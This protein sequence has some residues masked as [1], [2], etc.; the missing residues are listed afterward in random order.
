MPG[1][2]GFSGGQGAVEFNTFNYTSGQ[3]YDDL[4]L[5][6]GKHSLKFGFNAE[7]RGHNFNQTKTDRGYIY[8]PTATSGRINENF[9]VICAVQFNADSFYQ[10][11]QLA[12]RKM[13]SRGFQAQASYTW[14]KSIDTASVTF[15]SNEYTNTVNNPVPFDTRVSRG[16]SDFDVRHNFVLNFVWDIPSPGAWSSMARWLARGWQLG[17]ICQAST[18]TPFSVGISGDKE[19]QLDAGNEGAIRSYGADRGDA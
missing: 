1:L 7:H 16:L 5:T 18:G 14:G 11:L 10:G 3:I 13:L 6:R 8:P 4:F 9:G 17:G 2:T 12:I 15:S 19:V